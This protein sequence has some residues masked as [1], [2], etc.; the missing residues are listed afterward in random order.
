MSKAPSSVSVSRKAVH[1][2]CEI[3]RIEILIRGYD[4]HSWAVYGQKPFDRKV[5]VDPDEI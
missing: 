2:K 5:E 1:G 4:L 3:E